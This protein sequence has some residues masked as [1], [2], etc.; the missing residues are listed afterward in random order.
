LRSKHF[1][2]DQRILCDFCWL[3][4]TT[5]KQISRL[6]ERVAVLFIALCTN[7]SQSLNAATPLT[8]CCCW[9]H[10]GPKTP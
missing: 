3:N 6:P 4:M 2:L 5:K 8:F 10:Q 7:Y 9:C 1:A